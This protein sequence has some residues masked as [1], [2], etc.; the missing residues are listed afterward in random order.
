MT[1][2]LLPRGPECCAH[3]GPRGEP[4]LPARVRLKA[5]DDQVGVDQEE[6][7]PTVGQ[8][9]PHVANAG[10]FRQFQESLFQS[11]QDAVSRF[12]IVA[13]D[14]ISSVTDVLFRTG[15]QNEQFQGLERFLCVLRCR[16]LENA[17]GPS[18]NRP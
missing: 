1:T 16:I 8:L 15:C 11:V 4:E 17:S 7:V 6:P 5:V 12:D 10:T 2:V 18:T 9:L 14:V 3:L 13:S